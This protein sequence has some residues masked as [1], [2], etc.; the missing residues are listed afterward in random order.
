MLD[1][2]NELKDDMRDKYIEQRL[3]EIKEDYF[4][5]QYLEDKEINCRARKGRDYRVGYERG[6]F[7]SVKYIR[8]NI[9]YFIKLQ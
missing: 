2:S 3:L 8:R 1:K 4:P 7:N 9:D 5:S 6:F